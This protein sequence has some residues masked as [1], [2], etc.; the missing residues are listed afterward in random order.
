MT[1]TMPTLPGG[2]VLELVRTA[3]NRIVVAAPYI[4]SK[5][6]RRLFEAF[7]KTVMECICVT[8]W[9]PE[10]IVSGVCDLEILDDVS[11][12]SGGRLLI[13]PNL[14]AKYYSNGQNTLVGSANLTSRGLGWH[15]PSNVELLVELPA[16]FPG[17]TDWEVALLSSSIDATEQLREQIRAQAEHLRQSHSMYLLPEVEAETGENEEDIWVP[18]CPTP[19]RLWTVYCGHGEDTMVSSAY[20]AACDDLAALLPPQGLTEDLFTVYVAGILRQTPLFIE[21]DRLTSVGLTDA[22]A[23]ELLS[24]HFDNGA[25][26]TANNNQRWHIIKSWLMHFFPKSYLLETDQEV[27]IKGREINL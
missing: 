19:E 13:H 20:V 16:E 5:T 24:D 18:R 9:R 12:M 15:T 11:Q 1:D 3:T 26:D 25:K 17:L 4:K 6:I 27:L 23:Q 14:H 22:K 7:P 2:A 21:I 10:D 8:R